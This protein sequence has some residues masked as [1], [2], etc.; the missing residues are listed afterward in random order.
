MRH[1]P[2]C[3]LVEVLKNFQRVVDLPLAQWD[4]L[5]RQ[6]R[7]ADLLGRLAEILEGQSLFDAIPEAPRQHLIAGRA[8]AQKHAQVMRWEIERIQEAL[9]ALGVPVIYLKGAAY[10]LRGLPPARGRIYSD[11]DIMV[12]KAALGKVEKALLIHGWSALKL[13]A[14]DQRYY[15]QWMHEI[16]PLRHR[17]RL[18]V[19]D[20]HH[21]IL[22]E[23]TRAQPDPARMLAA[24]ETVADYKNALTLNPVDM[25]IHSATHLFYE[26][27]FD[28]GLRDLADL[29]D[30]LRHFSGHPGFW[31]KLVHRAQ[32]LGL[33]QPLYY[34]LRYCGLVL[35]TPVP[36]GA[37]EHKHMWQPAVAR[38]G[39]MDFLFL[40]ALLPM[41][42][43]CERRLSGLARFVLYVRSHYLRM[44]VYLLLPHL[45]RKLYS[46]DK[47]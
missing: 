24:A 21:R 15:R 3:I 45:L 6:A 4:S 1:K 19:I 43:S 23:T 18:T 29:D 20:V 27:E 42:A 28:H 8:H 9:A 7:R 14:Y 35:G 41:H 34:A 25:V 39:M 47:E 31:D 32:E 38:R 40:R 13:D 44:P 26:G 30:L 11:V 16:P 5:I 2:V 37:W 10:V 33:I 17:R 12:P 22:P 36:P 46:K